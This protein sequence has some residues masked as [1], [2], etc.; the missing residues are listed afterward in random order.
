MFNARNKTA[1]KKIL[2]LSVIVRR[3]R[4]S[5]NKQK[6]MVYRGLQS[7]TE[8]YEYIQ[9]Q[10][11][12]KLNIIPTWEGSHSWGCGTAGSSRWARR[13]SRPAAGCSPSTAWTSPAP[14]PGRQGW[15][16]S[17]ASRTW[18][19]ES[20][21]WSA[22]GVGRRRRSGP[23]PAWR[24]CQFCRQRWRSCRRRSPRGTRRPWWR[25]TWSSGWSWWRSGWMSGP[26]PPWRCPRGWSR[27]G[28][29][30]AAPTWAL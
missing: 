24:R 15:T 9:P 13:P 2:I 17:A 27:R 18:W 22:D 14:D 20:R 5:S 28:W 26:R 25:G 23:W 4:F 1:L 21:G 12:L 8:L 16:A 10:N 30:V 19:P 6:N 11:F 29:Q 7:N 3:Y